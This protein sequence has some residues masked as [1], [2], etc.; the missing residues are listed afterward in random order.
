MVLLLG[1]DDGGVN[2]EQAGDGKISAMGQALPDM[3]TCP[4]HSL[5]IHRFRSPRRLPIAE[6]LEWMR[7]V[8]VDD[9]LHRAK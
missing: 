7:P 5:R 1:E 8:A 2:E 9:K 3:P 4:V 6:S